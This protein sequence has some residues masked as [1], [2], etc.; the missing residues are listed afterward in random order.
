[1]KRRVFLARDGLNFF[2]AV[3]AFGIGGAKQAAADILNNY[4]GAGRIYNYTPQDMTMADTAPEL[5]S[6]YSFEVQH[7]ALDAYD[8]KRLYKT[9]LTGLL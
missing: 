6:G 2:I 9:N 4:M 5:S 3:E 7:D 1:M 8:N